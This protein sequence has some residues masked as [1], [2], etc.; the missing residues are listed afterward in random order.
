[1]A[2]SRSPRLVTVSLC[3]IAVLVATAVAALSAPVWAASSREDTI[4]VTSS[5]TSGECVGSGPDD[6]GKAFC[7]GDQNGHVH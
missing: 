5:C 3:K 2:H 7:D 1:M 4:V 6:C